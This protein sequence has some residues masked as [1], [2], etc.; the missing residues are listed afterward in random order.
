V[1]GGKDV[2]L[3]EIPWQAYLE[4][5]HHYIPDPLHCGGVL[6]DDDVV[7]TAAHCVTGVSFP[8]DDTVYS[9]L[10]CTPFGYLYI[11]TVVFIR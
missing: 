11:Y 8:D 10:I 6:V 3:H 4:I 1:T 2:K 7:L 5:Q 9:I